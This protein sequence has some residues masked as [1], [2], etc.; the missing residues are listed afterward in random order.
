MLT[1]LFE[2]LCEMSLI[3]SYTILVV[4]LARVFLKRCGRKYAYVLWGIVLINLCVPLSL[5]APIS[6]IPKQ[7]VAEEGIRRSEEFF[8]ADTESSEHGK[9]GKSELIIDAQSSRV[10]VLESLLWKVGAR[11]AQFILAEH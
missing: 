8:H 5:R 4:L 7:I 9:G 11:K 3:G 6:L 2:R 10:G 1:T